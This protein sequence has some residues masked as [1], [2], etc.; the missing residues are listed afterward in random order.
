M[1]TRGHHGLLLG[2]GGGSPTW[3]EVTSFVPDN[4]EDGWA[5]YT[6]RQPIVDDDLAGATILRATLRCAAGKALSVGSAYAGNRAG[7]AG[8]IGFSGSPVQLTFGG[9]PNFSVS[10]AVD[11][12]SDP[13]SLS[14]IGTDIVISAYFDATSSM[15]SR[16]TPPG[17]GE[18]AK[19]ILGDDAANPTPTGY[20]SWANY[21]LFIKLE[22]LV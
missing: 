5:G 2:H 9:N 22:K 10:G 8:G 15:V 16:A 20:T 17:L 7:G 21:G 11:T 1:S 6:L 3:V 14:V 13:F 18:F 19:Y 12:V 4:V